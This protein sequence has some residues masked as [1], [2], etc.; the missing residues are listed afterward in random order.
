MDRCIPD[1]LGAL[2]SPKETLQGRW[3][4]DKS[5]LHINCLELRAIALTLKKKKFQNKT[6]QLFTDSEVV[7]HILQ[8]KR[9]KF[10]HLLQEYQQLLQWCL[11]HVVIILPNRVPSHLNVVADGL[12][13]VTTGHRVETT[14]RNIFTDSEM[15]RTTYSRSYGNTCKYT[16]SGVCMPVS[17]SVCTG[18]RL[19]QFRLG[20]LRQLLSVLTCADDSDTDVSDLSIQGEDSCD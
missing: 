17:S 6:I 19:S 18:S 15:G 12:S 13:R 9:A 8:K 1:R 20:R 11:A 10:V 5:K 3:T 2:I 7:R 14:T 16:H 4:Q